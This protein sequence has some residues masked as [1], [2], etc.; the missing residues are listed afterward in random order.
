MDAAEAERDVAIA[1]MAAENAGLDDEEEDDEDE[2]PLIAHFVRTATAASP[3]DLQS[4]I[5]GVANKTMQQ[6]LD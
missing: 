6:Q 3:C 2:D 4:R 5:R 1:R